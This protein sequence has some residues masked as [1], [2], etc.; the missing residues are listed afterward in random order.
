[1]AFPSTKGIMFSLPVYG[2][3]VYP[4]LDI[5]PTADIGFLVVSG[6]S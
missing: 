6:T 5:D 1:M 3:L 4:A 2:V